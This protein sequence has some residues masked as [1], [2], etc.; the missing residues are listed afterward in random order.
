MIRKNYS[1]KQPQPFYPFKNHYPRLTLS[2][3]ITDPY[4][5]G[6]SNYRN[7]QL[8]NPY[9]LFPE[10]TNYIVSRNTKHTLQK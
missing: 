1:P 5:I 4:N 9:T 8:R 3:P 2:K 7:L 10:N 6:A